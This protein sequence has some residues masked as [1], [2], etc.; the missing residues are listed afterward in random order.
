MEFMK[1]NC[2]SYVDACNI[3]CPHYIAIVKFVYLISLQ[4][5][6]YVANHLIWIC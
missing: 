3:C 1:L 2:I 6:P 4:Y 5:L